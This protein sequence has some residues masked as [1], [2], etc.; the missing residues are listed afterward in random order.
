M[1]AATD[2]KAGVRGVKAP[3]YQLPIAPLQWASRAFHYGSEKYQDG[4]YLRAP[5]TGTD[6]ERLLDYLSAAGR[7]LF[8]W[9]TEIQRMRGAGRNGKD[10]D[11][12]IYAADSESG[13]PHGCH[14]LASLCMAIQQAV[15]AGLVPEDPGITWKKNDEGKLVPK[16]WAEWRR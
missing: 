1:E 8:Q 14:A 6:E 5:A 7:H 15:D 4:N 13:L 9:A 11:Q 12:A 3:L 16:E 10:E 2:M